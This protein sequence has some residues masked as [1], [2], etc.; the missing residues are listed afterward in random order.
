MTGPF[1]TESHDFRAAAW[2][3]GGGPPASSASRWTWGEFL[4][5]GAILIVATLLRLREAMSFPLGFDEIYVIRVAQQSFG[6]AMRLVAAD[7]HP[8]LQYV[9]HWIWLRL[10]GDGPLWFRSLSILFTLGSMA[11]TYAL[12]RRAFGPRP[13]LFALALITLNPSHLFFSVVADDYSLEWL[14][15]L[16]AMASGWAWIRDGRARDAVLYVV[17]GALATYS[18]YLSLFVVLVLGIAG[19]VL[20][21]RRARL[22]WLLLHVVIAA[23]FVP[24]VPTFVD[25]FRREGAG[26]YFRFPTSEQILTLWRQMSFNVRWLV[27]LMF[28]LAL[29]PLA[30]RETRRATLFLWVMCTIPLLSTRGYV[31]IFPREVLHAVPLWLLLAAGGLATIPWRGVIMIGGFVL[32]A[33]AVRATLLQSPHPETV[34]FGKAAAYLRGQVAPGDLVVHAES[35]SLLFFTYYL[36]QATN[37]ILI[38]SGDRIPFFDGGLI[39]ADSQYIAPER[40]SEERSRGTRWWGVWS[41]RAVASKGKTWRAG[42]LAAQQFREAGGDSVWQSAPVTIWRGVGR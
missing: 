39:V 27:P 22:R 37:R 29:L 38:R 11:A 8:P 31:V 32:L 23:A 19:F 13:A 35:H 16:A 28:L 24:Q 42:A 41:N 20:M 5:L 36:P 3:S 6:E 15:L 30:R 9:L 17:T 14:L 40:W 33:G 34:A 25:Q 10:G 2:R 12:G 7:I 26:A 4:A 1:A 21:E 18:H